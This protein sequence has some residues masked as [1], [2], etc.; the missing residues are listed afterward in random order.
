MALKPLPDTGIELGKEP[1]K[2]KIIREG[3]GSLL[4]LIREVMYFG[5]KVIKV[6]QKNK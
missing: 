6:I 5:K 4:F 3:C 2:R 1:K